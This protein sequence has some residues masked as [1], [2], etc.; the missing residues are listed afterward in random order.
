MEIHL[1]TVITII[2]IAC[3]A[4]SGWIVSARSRRRMKQGLGRNVDDCEMTSLGAWMQVE[5]EESRKAGG[6]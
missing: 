2:A 4:V 3:S 5:D 1:S 6:K